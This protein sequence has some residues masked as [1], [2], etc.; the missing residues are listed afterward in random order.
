MRFFFYGTLRDPQLLAAVLGRPPPARRLT[1]VWLADHAAKGVVGE[2]YPCLLPA[3]GERV[4]GV[5]AHGLDARAAGRIAF[6]EGPEYRLANVLVHRASGGCV[7]ARACLP[8]SPLLDDGE[9]WDYDAWRRDH[10]DRQL[11][12]ARR[13]MRGDVTALPAALDG[14]WR[15]L[16]SQA[17][18]AR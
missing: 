7:L 2:S 9:I 17:G 14:R 1:S 12:R 11:A 10:R 6:Y 8:R 18:R 4:E 3:P 15:R 16:D 5:L 13:W